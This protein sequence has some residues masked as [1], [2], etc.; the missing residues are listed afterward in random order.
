VLA[1]DRAAGRVFNVGGAAGYTTEQF[2]DVVRRQYG[3][4][5]PGRISGE[6]RF[7]DTRHILSDIDALKQLGF[8]GGIGTQIT[9]PNVDFATLARAYDVHGEGPV[10]QLSELRPAVERALRIVKDQG[11]MAL[12]DVVC[13]A[14]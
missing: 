6:Y 10:T 5:E 1:D 14:R 8:I 2:A 4:D 9:G 12:V 11:K 7:G 3:S 13:E